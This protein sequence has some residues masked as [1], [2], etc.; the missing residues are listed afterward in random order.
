MSAAVYDLR[1]GFFFFAFAT[2]FLLERRSVDITRSVQ[3]SSD[4][5]APSMARS[6]SAKSASISETGVWPIPSAYLRHDDAGGRCNWGDHYR[7]DYSVHFSGMTLPRPV[8]KYDRWTGK[9]QQYT[10]Q[11]GGMACTRFRRHRVKVFNGAG[12]RPWRD[13]SLRGSSSLRL[14]D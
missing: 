13:G 7:G 1:F 14:C 2:L 3:S 5:G 9:L 6:R 10:V 8:Y 12:G 4:Q 11:E